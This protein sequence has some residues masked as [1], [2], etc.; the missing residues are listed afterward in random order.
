MQIV[1]K[2]IEQIGGRIKPHI[3]LQVGRGG[4]HSDP[5]C[6]FRPR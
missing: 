3:A 1:S 5:L 6:F 2:N 4:L